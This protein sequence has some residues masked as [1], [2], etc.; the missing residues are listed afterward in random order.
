LHLQDS[1][2]HSKGTG[3]WAGL[4]NLFWW[5][6]RQK[7]VGGMI[8]SQILPFGDAKVMGCWGQ[9]QGGIYGNLEQSESLPMR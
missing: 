2:V 3:W 5:A 8:A 6:D 7:G 4:A 9:V 1:A